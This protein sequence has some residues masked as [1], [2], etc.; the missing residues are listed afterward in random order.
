M[1]RASLLSTFG[2]VAVVSLTGCLEAEATGGEETPEEAQ[3][4]PGDPAAPAPAAPTLACPTNVPA[5]INPA[6]DQ[7]LA[8]KYHAVGV[9]VYECK[10]NGSGGY[11]WAFKEPRA[12]LFNAKNE[13]VGTHYAGPTWEHNDGSS[14][15]GAKVA[16]APGGT[17]NDIPWLLL[18][19]VSYG[20]VQGKFSD[21]TNIQRLNTV[22]GIAPTTPCAADNAGALSEEAYEADYLFYRTEAVTA[23][24]ELHCGVTPPPAEI[25][26]P[27]PTP[28]I[29]KPPPEHKL[30]FK[31]HAV[32]AQVYECTIPA[33]KSAF[34]W[35]FVEPRAALYNAA[36]QE[37]G[38][39]FAGPTWKHADG[40]AITGAKRQEAPGATTND[41]PWLL[42]ATQPTGTVT[43][44][45][46]DVTW[47]QRLSTQGGVKPSGQCDKTHSPDAIVSIP[48]EADY[49]FYRRDDA[50]V[51][52]NKQC[53]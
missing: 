39:H 53:G 26:C 2:V 12:D 13:K 29:L 50:N 30:A 25:T 48:Y 1:N 31:Y 51:G 10:V 15:K 46:T 37:V 3:P 28:S 35:V 5:A 42:L 19:M 9:Q 22:G 52:S 11:A 44:K 27:S 36:G 17:A 6:A 4:L 8:F 33:G 38:S 20:P 7:K 40:S 32:G 14:A 24:S 18:N 45:F 47:I 21:V 16:D 49:Y 34:E 43:G 23:G 41:I